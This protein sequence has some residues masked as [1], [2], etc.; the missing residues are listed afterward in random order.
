MARSFSVLQHLCAL[1]QIH[2][3]FLPGS[4][5]FDCSVHRDISKWRGLQLRHEVSFSNSKTCSV[6]LILRAR[7]ARLTS[8][9]ALTRSKPLALPVSASA[10]PSHH[11][12]LP[13]PLPPH[14]VPGASAASIRCAASCLSSYSRVHYTPSLALSPLPPLPKGLLSQ[15]L[16]ETGMKGALVTIG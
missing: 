10:R 1:L 7:T 12:S 14:S 8:D 6:V 9:H 11:R 2:S 3:D 4:A 16:G 13:V 15:Y 5:R